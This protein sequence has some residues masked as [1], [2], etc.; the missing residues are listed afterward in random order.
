MQPALTDDAAGTE[1]R[2]L[3]ELRFM[4]KEGAVEMAALVSA[5]SP[6]CHGEDRMVAMEVMVAAS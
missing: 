6:T 3:I 2:L 1:P 5:A 4:S